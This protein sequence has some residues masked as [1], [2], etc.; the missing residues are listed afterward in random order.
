M[1]KSIY[2]IWIGGIWV[3]AIARY[4][5]SQWYTVYWDDA[6]HSELTDTLESE[7][8]IL[9]SFDSAFKHWNIS[10][11][12]YSEAIPADN[13]ELLL[14]TE[15]NIQ[16]LSYPEALAEIAN[17]KKLIAIAGT[18]GK[19]TTTSLTSLVLK[20][21]KENFTAVVGTLLKEF[22]NK[23]FFHKSKHIIPPLSK[24]VRGNTLPEN[25]DNF[26]VIEACEYKRSFLNYTPTVG[27][28]TNIELDH[29]DY[30]KDE[31]DY[32]SAFESF[33]SNI[34]SGGFA[35]LNGD[36]VNCQ[37]LKWLRD[38][39]QYIEIFDDYFSFEEKVFHYPEITLQVAGN[40]ILY[41]AKIAYVVGHM[42][43][44][45]DSQ[46]VEALENYTGV[47]RRMEIIK[48]TDNWNTL[49]SDY[50]HHPTEIK[51]TLDALKQ[52]YPDTSLYTI[53][54][55]HQ[56]NRTLE[57]IK[58]FRNCFQSTN[59][60]VIPNIYA[61]RDTEEDKK[62]MPVEKFISSI[63]HPNIIH[64]DWLENTLKLIKAYDAQDPNSS[65][66]LLLGAWN[67]D[68]LRFEI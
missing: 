27:I 3:S 67:V 49:M 42:L 58:E 19:S 57:L 9:C 46:I 53:F 68:T 59:T 64:G 62:N 54:Q 10:K 65:I 60:L 66:I 61:S 16:I 23:N 11:L 55:P 21:S 37:K 56:Y 31:A 48:T 45:A 17:D 25:Q 1:Q 18:H 7:W 50:G 52:K 47:W 38:D 43:G 15:K 41:D 30:F 24:G 51:L 32:L 35:I 39:I 29:L 22:D 36:D 63:D 6:T 14:A 40:H 26:F 20:N 34:K 28:I 12:I 13:H 4:Y 8:I 5:N 2:I 44:I 33:L